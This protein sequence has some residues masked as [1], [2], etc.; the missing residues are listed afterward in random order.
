MKRS[1]PVKNDARG[2]SHAGV[3]SRS[4]GVLRS[5]RATMAEVAAHPTWLGM[6]AF[7]AVTIAI[8]SF[9]FLSTE[10]GESALLDAA[11][12]QLENFGVEVD[13]ARYGWLMDRVAQRPLARKCF[14]AHRDSGIGARRGSR[15]ILWIPAGRRSIG[16]LRSRLRDRGSQRRGAVPAAA[17]RL[18]IELYQR[19]AVGTD[20]PG[21]HAADARRNEPAGR[22]PGRDRP[23]HGVVVAGRGDWPFRCLSGS[24]RDASLFDCWR[25]TS[26]WSWA[27]R[28]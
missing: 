4:L 13:D 18:A 3:I 2:H 22:L 23:L 8:L 19:V 16:P 7:L 24:R 14:S 28:S 26:W 21:R 12:R 17:R 1:D 6:L 20:Q 25:A 27:S 11:V 5:P 15:H 9:A 10:S